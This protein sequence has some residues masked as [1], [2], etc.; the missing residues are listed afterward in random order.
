MIFALAGGIMLSSGI[1]PTTQ[2]AS[3]LNVQVLTN[4]AG[5]LSRV[6][7]TVNLKNTIIANNISSP[8]VTDVRGLIVS[9]GNNLI[10][11]TTGGIGFIAS[12]LQNVNPLLGGF[13]NNGGTTYTISLLAGSPAINAGNNTG[14]TV[15]DQRGVPRPQNETVDIGAFESGVPFWNGQTDAGSNIN[16]IMGTVSATFSSII[17]SG[18]TNA[19][20]INPTTAGTLPGG[21][22]LGAG[23]PAYEITTTAIFTPPI[24]V[25]L[26]VPGVTNPMNFASLRILHNEGGTLVDRTILPPYTPAPDFATKTICARV[27][28]LSPFVVAEIL[29]PSANVSVGGQVLASSGGISRARVSIT[30]QNDEIRETQTNSFGYFRFDEIAAGEVYV[31]RVRHKRFQFINETQIVVVADEITDLSF[32]ALPE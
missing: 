21:Y 20:P 6:A 5:G 27:S 12:D 1:S 16:V 14:A 23:Y 32:I 10:G 28:F 3:A 24:I 19:V 18:T 2:H 29:S 4:G 13:A 8:S 22:S 11:N 17:T 9:Q 25:C 7:G 26:Q 31:I 30:N 15:T